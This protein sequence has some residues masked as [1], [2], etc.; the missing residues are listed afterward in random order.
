MLGSDEVQQELFIQAQDHG[1]ALIDSNSQLYNL[2][3]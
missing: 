1:N 2:Q 3:G